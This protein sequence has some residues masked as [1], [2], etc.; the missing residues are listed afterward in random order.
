MTAHPASVVIEAEEVSSEAALLPIHE[1]ATYLRDH[2]GLRMTAY[3]SGVSDARMV[4][5][6]IMRDHVPRERR[7]L[8]LREAYQAARLVV[9]AH[10]D[11]TAKA[12]FFGSNARLAGKAPA[13]VLRQAGSWEDLRPI[14]PAARLFAQAAGDVSARASS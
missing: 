8:R 13:Y 7:Q 9:S 11:E 12:W 3:L 5:H 10:G 14:V 4:S 6:W 1:I 2:L